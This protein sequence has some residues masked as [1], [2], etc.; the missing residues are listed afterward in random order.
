MKEHYT[1]AVN[2]TGSLFCG[3]HLIWNY[4]QGHINHHM[5]RNINKAL[6]KYQH[7]KPVSPQHA[8]DKTALI[9]Y[10][11]QVQRVK[12]DTTQPLTPREIIHVQDIVGTLL[13]YARAVDPTLLAALSAIAACQSNSTRAVADACHQLLNYVATHP[14][15]GI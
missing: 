12:V 15:A 10:G 8:P 2:M 4:S 9:Q 3:I 5:P 14:N 6:M 13:Y 11:A 1:V 7:P